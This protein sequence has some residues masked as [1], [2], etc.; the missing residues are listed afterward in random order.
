M[1][2]IKLSN[3]TIITTY[4]PVPKDFDFLNA[5]DSVMILHGYPPRPTSNTKLSSIWHKLILKKSNYI[6]PTF[7]PL[8]IR[9]KKIK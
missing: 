8:Y 2:K 5:D 9:N 4:I 7:S 6:V 3:G 1:A